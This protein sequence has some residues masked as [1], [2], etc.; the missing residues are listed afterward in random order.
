MQVLA[1]ELDIRSGSTWNMI[2]TTASAK[3]NFI[4]LQEVGRFFAGKK[5]YTTRQGLDSFLIKLTVSGGGILEYDGHREPVAPGHFYW[6][7]CQNWQNY[8]TDPQIGHWDIIWVH[9]YGATARPY[10]ETFRKLQGAG[11]IVSALSQGSSMLALM[12]TMLGR[13]TAAKKSL[14]AEQNLYEF[15]VQTSGLLTQLIME[16]L[17]CVGTSNKAEHIPPM[18][19]DIRNYI[20]SHYNEKTTLAR[21][22][23]HFNLD[24]YYLQKLFKRYI[25]QSPMEYIIY[26]RMSHAKNLIRTSTMSISEIAYTVGIDNISHFTRQFKKLEGMTPGHYRRLW[27]TG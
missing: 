10:Y 8:Y 15:D 26:L 23:A 12:E 18:V 1:Y 3:A 13:S 4:Y 19:R 24:P 7:D 21:L 20:A 25:G 9:F 22:A 6:I 2:A 14:C 11:T 5:Y 16:C 17:S 27:P